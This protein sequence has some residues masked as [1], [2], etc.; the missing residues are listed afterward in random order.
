MDRFNLELPINATG[1]GNVGWGI[2]YEMFQRGLTPNIFP[3]GQIDLRPFKEDH[4]FNFW[5]EQGIKK[6]LKDFQNYPTITLWH[7]NGSHKKIGAKNV[8]YTVHEASEITPV[9]KEILS[10]H[11]HVCVTSS[12]SKTVFSKGGVEA[13]VVPNFFDAIH[14]R[15]LSRKYKQE[16]VITFGLFGKFEKRKHTI[17]QVISWANKYAGNKEFRLNALIHNHFIDPN[18]LHQQIHQIFGGK[19]VPFNINFLGWCEKNVDFNEIINQTD[20]SLNLNGAEGFNL[21]NLTSLCLG[22]QNVVLNAHAH[23]DYCT[24]ENSILVE[25]NGMSDIYDGQFFVKGSDFNQGDFYT[26]TQ[27]A[28]H[29]AFDVAVQRVKDGIVNT[30]GEK[31]KDK[32]TV[33]GTVD[34]L[35]GLL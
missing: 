26:F 12:Y 31:L 18:V 9:E 8:L 4:N 19:T 7:I 32:F 5:L 28:A 13:E 35:L 10:G 14:F 16:G 25:P 15:K 17:N 29:E 11:D 34:K 27:E 22:K 3:L 24:E 23:L 2:A 6:A 20:I 33:G 30:E 1:L 21:T